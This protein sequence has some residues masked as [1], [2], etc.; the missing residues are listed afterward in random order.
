MSEANGIGDDTDGDLEARPRPRGDVVGLNYHDAR[1]R[2]SQTPR[3]FVDV[4][5]PRPLWLIPLGDD[6]RQIEFLGRPTTQ[7]HWLQS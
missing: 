2:V 6:D 4:Q 3:E 7:L 5:E 1:P